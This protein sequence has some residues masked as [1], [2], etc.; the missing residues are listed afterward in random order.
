[1][2]IWAENGARLA[3]CYKDLLIELDKSDK[4]PEAL[5]CYKDE[6]I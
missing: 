5:M 6:G 3:D 4:N 2:G 1:M